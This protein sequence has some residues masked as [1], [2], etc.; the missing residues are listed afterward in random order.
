MFVGSPENHLSHTRQ[1]H[2]LLTNTARLYPH[3]LSN[4]PISQVT[5]IVS[6]SILFSRING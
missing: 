3:I 2:F 5:N 4:S 1:A 6:Y